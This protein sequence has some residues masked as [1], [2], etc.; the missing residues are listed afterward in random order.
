MCEHT[1]GYV[2]RS[3]TGSLSHLFGHAW[4]VACGCPLRP[5]TNRHTLQGT[6]RRIGAFNATHPTPNAEDTKLCPSPKTLTTP[7]PARRT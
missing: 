2:R 5:R 7:L 3:G 6:H 4:D 1:V